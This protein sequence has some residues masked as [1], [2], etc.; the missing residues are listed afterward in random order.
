MRRTLFFSALL[1]LLWVVSSPAHAGLAYPDPAGGWSYIYAADEG[2]D[3]FGG[4]TDFD[5]L[6]GTWSHNNG[7][8]QWDGSAPGGTFAAGENA[9][10][11]AKIYSEGGVG[12]LRI[13]DTGDPR[14]FGYADPGNR[15]IYFGHD[16]SAHGAA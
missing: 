11:G 13:Q 14:D 7:S 6:D 8:D 3:V 9:P 15:K 4:G 16:I 10:G 2:Q 5:A 12:Y 1:A